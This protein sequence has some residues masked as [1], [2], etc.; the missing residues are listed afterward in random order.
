M[1]FL[2]AAVILLSINGSAS[3]DAGANRGQ[4]PKSIP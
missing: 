4:V 1:A 2:Q 3:R